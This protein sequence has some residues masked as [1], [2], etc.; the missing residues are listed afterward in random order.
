MLTNSHKSDLFVS[1]VTT[2][3]NAASFVEAFV[4]EASTL[5]SQ[6][7]KDYE[8]ILVDCASSDDTS[9]IIEHLQQEIKNIQVY[10]LT[11]RLDPDSAFVVGLEQAIGDIVITIDACYDP[12]DRI[13]DMITLYESNYE[14][15]MIYGLRKNPTHTALSDRLYDW[16]TKAFFWIHGMITKEAMPISASAFRLYSR[17]TLNTFLDHRDRY[18]LF[19]VIAAFSGYS[20]LE[21]PYDRVNRSGIHH[22][23]SYYT[24]LTRA[25][26]I[27]LLSSHQPIRLLSIG[28]LIGAFF[29]IL[30]TIYIVLVNIFK[31]HVAEGWTTLSLQ[32]ASMFFLLFMIL[33]ILCEYIVRMFMHGQDRPY[34][35]IAKERRS[36]V[37]SRKDAINVA[38]SSE[39]AARNSEDI[40][41]K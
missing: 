33:A 8:I 12:V 11:R 36:L 21:L 16:L 38:D 9:G 7:F 22:P 3:H 20:H 27:M 31:S 28:S 10:Y 2:I 23:R 14:V 34:Y 18:L 41:I 15:G 6:Y 29:N 5:L 1:I 19:P 40:N 32:M 4:R 39:L 13:V 25:L 24:G 26:R 30:Y 35:L 37:L 17:R